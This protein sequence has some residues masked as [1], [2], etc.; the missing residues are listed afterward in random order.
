VPGARCILPSQDGAMP[1]EEKAI[2]ITCAIA[3]AGISPTPRT[4]PQRR[5]AGYRL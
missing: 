3:S 2:H 5:S 4:F 1:D